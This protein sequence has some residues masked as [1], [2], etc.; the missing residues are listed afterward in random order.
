MEFRTGSKIQR[1]VFGAVSIFS[2][3][4]SQVII[5]MSSERCYNKSTTKHW[6]NGRYN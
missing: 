5:L 4:S 1:G 3:S 2:D 6:E